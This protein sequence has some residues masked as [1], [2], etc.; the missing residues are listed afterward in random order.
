MYSV[1]TLTG[2]SSLIAQSLRLLAP[3][4]QRALAVAIL[5]TQKSFPTQKRW[6]SSATSAA[7]SFKVLQQKQGK[8]LSSS[9]PAGASVGAK[10]RTLPPYMVFRYCQQSGSGQQ[11]H[12]SVQSHSTVAWDMS[13]HAGSTTVD[14]EMTKVRDNVFKVV[15]L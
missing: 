6:Q 7:V 4:D 2:S 3:S 9:A 8:V 11:R 12:N 14:A 5:F 13:H 1:R 10:G 15:K